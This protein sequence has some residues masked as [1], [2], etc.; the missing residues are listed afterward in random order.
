[1][2]PP[3]TAAKYPWTTPMPRSCPTTDKHRPAP[4]DR[5]RRPTR[6][7]N[8]GVV[9]WQRPDIL[10]SAVSGADGGVGGVRRHPIMGAIH[11]GKPWREGVGWQCPVGQRE[12]D[13]GCAWARTRIAGA[14]PSAVKGAS[15]GN[16]FP[17]A[18][19]CSPRLPA[20][21]PTCHATDSRCGSDREYP[22]EP[23]ADLGH[24]DTGDHG[25]CHHRDGFRTVRFQFSCHHGLL[26]VQRC[27]PRTTVDGDAQQVEMPLAAPAM[28]PTPAPVTAPGA[29]P[30]SMS[31]TQPPTAPPTA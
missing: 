4:T 11:T 24:Q 29:H 10:P 28:A 9:R 14:G 25:G 5:M 13:P 7:G 18:T 31:A 30:V 21:P 6:R 8:A 23:A 15:E 17:S 22:A 12:S 1:M 20:L 16:N 2:N 27:C 26:R 19:S 3:A